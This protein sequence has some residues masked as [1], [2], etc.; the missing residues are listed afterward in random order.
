MPRIIESYRKDNRS[1]CQ[2]RNEPMSWFSIT[3]I[4]LLIGLGAHALYD[5]YA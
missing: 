1:D 5:V 3:I 4:A 2:D